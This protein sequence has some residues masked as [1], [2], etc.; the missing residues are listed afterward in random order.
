M[1]VRVADHNF[2]AR[3][4]PAFTRLVTGVMMHPSFT[5]DVSSSGFDIALLQLQHPIDR[6]KH[7][8][9]HQLYR[10]K[11]THALTDGAAGPPLGD[12]LRFDEVLMTHLV[13][14]SSSDRIFF[15]RNASWDSNIL[16]YWR[17]LLLPIDEYE[18]KDINAICHGDSG[19]GLLC[20]HPDGSKWVVYGVFSTGTPNCLAG[21]NVFALTGTKLDWIE[22]VIRAN[23]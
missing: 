1:A 17:F 14:P 9:E 6:S 11:Q 18:L 7:N 12:E 10:T 21:F 2:T 13:E 15:L 5:Y 23:P 4:P 20:L 8:S 16:Y 3:N 19:G 22:Q